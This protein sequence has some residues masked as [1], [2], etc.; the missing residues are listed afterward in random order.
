MVIS[1]DL[2]DSGG[3]SGGG[4]GGGGGGADQG[5]MHVFAVA[6]GLSLCSMCCPECETPAPL[7]CVA[8]VITAGMQHTD[9]N[10]VLCQLDLSYLRQR[11]GNRLQW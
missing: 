6:D 7:A 1:T 4:G 11:H 5:K 9:H 10:L 2:R 3:V 8:M